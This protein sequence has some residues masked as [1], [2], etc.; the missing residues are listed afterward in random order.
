[1]ARHLCEQC[2]EPSDDIDGLCSTCRD[3]IER[4]LMVDGMSALEYETWKAAQATAAYHALHKALEPTDAEIARS[5]R[6]YELLFGFN[7][8]DGKVE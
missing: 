5:Q 8:D 6:R 2:N 4:D 7:E 1:M 3:Q